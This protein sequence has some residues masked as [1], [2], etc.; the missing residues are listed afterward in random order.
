MSRRGINR[1]RPRRSSFDP[2]VI[3]GIEWDSANSSPALTWLDVNG[4]AVTKDSA[5]FD[6]HP[7]FGNIVRCSLTAAGVATFGTDGK[8]TGLTLTD[9]Y[10]MVRIPR[11]YVKFE[12]SGTKYRWW[13]SPYPAPGY[14]LHPAFFQRGHALSPAEQVYVGAYTAGA[15]GGT[16]AANGTSNTIAASTYTGLKL[17]SKSGVKALASATLAQFEAAGN[18]IGTGWGNMNFWTLCL[19]QMLFYIEFASFNSQAV[20]GNGRTGG[21]NTAAS[22]CGT[23]LDQVGEGA[24]VDIQSLLAANGSYGDVVG[25]YRP[26]VW[27]GIENLFGNLW[28]FVAGYNTTDAEYRLLKRDGTGTI[29]A[30]LISGNYEA[31][32]SPKPLNGTDNISGTDGGNYCHGYVSDLA[33]DAAGLL[34]LAFVP[35]ALLGSSSMYLCDYH[36]SHSVGGTRILLAGGSWNTGGS[37]GVGCRGSDYGLSAANSKIGGRAEFLG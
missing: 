4:T 24:G 13:I 7:V 22:I 14:E 21:S 33:L 35:G 3:I 34:N 36:Y 25:S 29:A 37:A 26:V 32:T 30:E 8:G 18:L 10:V 15:D 2:S 1:R 20:L 6:A 12:V 23:Y 31:V 9:D 17:T 16:T 5:Y 19:L 11:V 27:R 28:Q